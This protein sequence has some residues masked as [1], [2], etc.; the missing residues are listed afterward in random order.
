MLDFIWLLNCK[1]L[2]TFNFNFKQN[3]YRFLLNLKYLHIYV[4]TLWNILC[5]VRKLFWYY[6]QMKAN[7]IPTGLIN[8]YASMLSNAVLFD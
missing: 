2:I 1:N 7:I 6:V 4:A 3:L 8:T 5:F